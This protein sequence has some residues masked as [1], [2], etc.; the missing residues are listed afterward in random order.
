[1]HVQQYIDKNQGNLAV[2]INDTSQFLE[3]RDKLTFVKERGKQV[4]RKILD[5]YQLFDEYMPSRMSDDFDALAYLVKQNLA[6]ASVIPT[7]GEIPQTGFGR[8][9]EFKGTDP[10]KLAIS[11]VYDEQ[12]QI[13]MLKFMNMSARFQSKAFTDLIFGSVDD[14]QPRVWKLSNVLAAQAMS[15]GVVRYTDSRSGAEAVLKYNVL[16]ELMPAPLTGTE[17]WSQLTTANGLR[18][19]QDH[20]EIFYNRHGFYPDETLMSK[21]DA[22]NL[23]MQTSTLEQT[24]NLGLIF[25]PGSQGQST[26]DNTMLTR[27]CERLDIPPIRIFDT[28]FEIEIAPNV[29]LRGR[30]FNQGSY[31]F[32][33]RPMGERLWLPT[34]EN[35]GKAGLY[36]KTEELKSSPPQDRC[37]TVGRNLPFINQPEMIA[38]RQIDDMA[39]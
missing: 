32:L 7:G 17:R 10:F 3:S 5:H 23:L 18:N 30:Y 36:T 15:K 28:Q 6:I 33:T 25:A 1:M 29:F 21:L 24:R 12:D 20:S 26:V 11:H 39:A 34:I 16:P 31:V 9:V 27:V 8:F 22:R 14:L 37:Y 19:L 2:V 13:N 35:E 38:S 4:D